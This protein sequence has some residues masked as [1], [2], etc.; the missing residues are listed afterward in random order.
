[1]T[2]GPEPRESATRSVSLANEEGVKQGLA[3]T[4]LGLWEIV[5]NLTRLQPS[6]R[7]RYRVKR[8][9][10]VG[11][12]L[13]L[14]I[15]PLAAC[16]QKWEQPN[17]RDEEMES[18]FFAGL[19][20][21]ELADLPEPSRLRPCC[22]FGH[23][24][25]VQIRSVP[26]P[27]YEIQ[28]VLD[29]DGLGTHK[30]NKG[31]LALQARGEEGVVSD[32]GS[33]ILYTC[34]GGFIDISHVRDNADRALF[35]AVQIGRL[36]ASGGSFPIAGE[37]AERRV[38]VRPLDARLVR[39]Y[40]IREVV[41]RL[42]EWLDFQASIWHEIATWYKWSSTRFSEQPSAFSAEDLYSNLIGAKIAAT[43]IR[44]QEASS[45][46]EYNRAVT[47]LLKDALAKLGP[48]PKE[49]TQRAFAYVDGIW[50]DSTKRVPDNQLVRHRNF[51]IGPSLSPWKL[52]DAGL[53][54]ALEA[55]RK[56]FDQFC[57]GNWAPLRLTV[58][59]RLGGVPLRKMAI[60]EIRPGE[61][62]V[63]NGFPSGIKVVTQE[64][65]PTI[66]QAIARA[67]EAELGAGVGSPLARA[68]E[69]TRKR[70]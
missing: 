39:T 46:I 8:R 23:D 51:N 70:Q 45:E 15:L 9:L 22:V 52:A 54:A 62:L 36:A 57:Q 24:I 34:R 47:A 14:L 10:R 56:E 18:A 26:M 13:V 43:V 65:L 58:A 7:A 12:W 20:T 68:G 40:G 11:L 28:N 6:R 60:L 16:Q 48:L 21:K 61:V 42:A 31:A 2:Q 29:I 59:D 37:G 41:V 69:N 66:I 3:D 30:Y 25:G 55:D 1:M 32:E 67:A 33:G 49:A 35:F 4:V 50:W 63:A 64:D 53:S 27:G 5:N 44:R 38:I 17:V 19:D